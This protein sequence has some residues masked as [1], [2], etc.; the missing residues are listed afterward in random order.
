MTGWLPGGGETSGGWLT[1][2]GF[3]MMRLF[4]REDIRVEVRGKLVAPRALGVEVERGRRDI[5]AVAELDQRPAH[6]IEHGAVAG[7]VVRRVVADAVHARAEGQVFD[8]A[9]AQQRG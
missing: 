3:F 5:G 8:G 2:V 7:V 4:Q 6:E 1:N 9:R